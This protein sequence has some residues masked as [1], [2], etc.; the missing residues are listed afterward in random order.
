VGIS[1][2]CQP[3]LRILTMAL[4]FVSLVCRLACAQPANPPAVGG[5][6]T[7]HTFAFKDGGSGVY[8]AFAVGQA[9]QP[10]AL[11]FFYGG[12]GCHSWRSVMPGYVAGLIANARVLVLNKRFVADAPDDSQTCSPQFNQANHP[13][14]WVLDYQEFIRAMLAAVP[15]KPRSVVL[16]GV[17]EG[18]LVAVKVAQ[19]MPEITHLAI[20]GDGAWSMRASLRALYQ[21]GAIPLDV[22]ANWH[23]IAA[24][25]ISLTKQWFGN[26]YKWWADV[27]DIEPLNDYLALSIPVVVGFGEKDESV[28]VESAI[29]LKAAFDA[30]GKHNLHLVVYPGANHRLV[31]G[32]KAYRPEFFAL[33]S[34]QL[35]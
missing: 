5:P 13:E 12:S 18:A 11:V 1:I 30:A 34:K 29:A 28:P 9:P 19:A 22:D 14:Q 25:P 20:I 4:V 15:R 6:L 32:E 16:V 35:Q 24:D 33:L 3:M 21:R 31:A 17:S 10:D 8:Y 7:P 27:M 2:F 23:N 26:P